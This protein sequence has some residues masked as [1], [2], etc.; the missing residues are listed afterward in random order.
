MQF[1][2][3]LFRGLLAALALGASVLML[4]RLWRCVPVL[5]RSVLRNGAALILLALGVLGSI[6][7]VIPG[8]VF[9]LLALIVMDVPQK[10]AALRRLEHSWLMRK[11]LQSKA[12]AQTWRALRRHARR[13]KILP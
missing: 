5:W 9:L 1:L 3:T 10:R 6:L 7:P 11:L 12:F 2:W 4:N 13:E 8:F